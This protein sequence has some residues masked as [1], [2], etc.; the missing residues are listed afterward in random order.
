MHGL[1]YIKAA[2]ANVAKAREARK[3]TSL[4]V[5]PTWSAILPS[6]VALI[7]QGG[8][9]GRIATEELRNMAHAADSAVAQNK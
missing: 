5:T 6:I 7:E 1:E 8:D 9:G 2:N 4:D 3:V